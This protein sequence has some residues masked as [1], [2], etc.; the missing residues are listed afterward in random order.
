M[1]TRSGDIDPSLIEF[2]SL[3]E[4]MTLGEIDNMLNKQ[5]GLLGVSGLTSDMRELLA[6]EAEHGDRRARLAIDIFCRRPAATWAPTSRRWAEPTPWS[7]PAA[8]AKTRAVVRERICR[9]LER[10]GLVV[11][12][13]RNSKL[14]PGE[15]GEISRERLVPARLRHSHERGAADRPRHVPRGG[16]RGPAVGSRLA[17]E[18]PPTIAGSS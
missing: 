8:S 12:P 10:L 1:G 14:G 3:K 16:R 7:S 18:S 17:L 4:G 6:E 5:S 9:G 13:E 15:S 11:D 2:L